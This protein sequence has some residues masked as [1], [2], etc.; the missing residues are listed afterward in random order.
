MRPIIGPAAHFEEVEPMNNGVYREPMPRAQLGV[1]P[2]D[3]D[4]MVQ[5]AS[6][7][8]QALGPLYSRYA[9]LIF[10][11]AAQSL[12]RTLA[13]EVVQEVFLTAWRNAGAFD[14]AQGAFRP[15]LMRL[16]HWRILNELRRRSR[17]P[18]DHKANTGEYDQE[19]LQQVPDEDPGPEERA[20]RKEHGQIV[21]SALDALPAK[22]RQA[23]AL[24]FLEELT[25]EQVAQTLD[26]PLGTAK[27]RIR[28]GLASL[29]V[30]LAPVAASLLGLGLA[31][32][33]IRAMQTQV[34]YDRNERALT[35]VTTSDLV[36]L[37][38]SPASV[39]VPAH[40]HANYRSRAGNDLVVLTVEALPGLTTG[41][42]YQAWAKH[43]ERWTSLGT[44][45]LDSNDSA[46][47]IAENPVLTTPPD[48]LE[49]TVEQSGG[50]LSPSGPV[51]LAWGNA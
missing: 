10:H 21:H 2:T 45:A 46:R 44:F 49:V 3:E 37:R 28:S 16:A 40:A 50:S 6:G 13:E 9:G 33:G 4:L 11:L 32:V 35:L 25:H 38:L 36:P 14:P 17:R 24:A 20:W 43:G 22:Q 41:Q 27:T 1:G 42:T 31:V 18:H 39:D 15:W 48:G 47:L 29:R 23:V 8:Q 26:V 12:N 5:L 19:P 51:V 30:R 34:A 7:Q